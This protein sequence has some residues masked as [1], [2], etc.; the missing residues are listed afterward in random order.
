MTVF[1]C[2]TFFL[3]IVIPPIVVACRVLFKCSNR[4]EY[5]LVYS[6]VSP[7]SCIA[8]HSYQIVFA[9]VIN[10]YHATSILLIYAIIA[11][12]NIQGFQ[13]LFYF[14]N[15]FIS[16]SKSSCCSCCFPIKNTC[17]RYLTF[18]SCFMSEFI[19]MGAS[20]ALS[21][22]LIAKLPLSNAIDD[23]PNRL[24]VIY[25]VS[26][27]F[28]AALIAFQVLFRQTN[29][30]FDVYIKAVDGYVAKSDEIELH[31][32]AQDDRIKP[33]KEL[34][35]REK[36]TLLAKVAISY[37]TKDFDAKVN[38]I[39]STELKDAFLP[40]TLTHLNGSNDSSAQRNAGGQGDD[41]LSSSEDQQDDNSG[42]PRSNGERLMR[43]D[44]ASLVKE[45]ETSKAGGWFPCCNK[46]RENQ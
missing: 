15:K 6:M 36:E 21:I 39:S 16:G 25:Q 7:F 13:K 20:I 9:F 30:A 46:K 19:F 8:S 34:S 42:L 10:P 26:V 38:L 23:A 5:L 28:F 37:L 14:V 33:W 40:T 3:F 12:V 22:T 1:D 18:V 32:L 31:N 41:Q 24:F 11:F 4:N 17:G 35:E 44:R 43:E 29:S 45:E 2:I 27:T